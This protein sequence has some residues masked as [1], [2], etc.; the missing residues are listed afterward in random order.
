MFRDVI[1]VISV[2]SARYFV[3][4]NPL[5]NPGRGLCFQGP[6]RR[7]PEGEHRAIPSIPDQLRRLQQ[8]QLGQRRLRQLAGL[9]LERQEHQH[10][11]RGRRHATAA[12]TAIQV[13]VV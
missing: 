1:Y 10:P 6:E 12:A 7:Q 11:Q 4:W 2:L 5:P 9:P 13:R 3:K 8:L